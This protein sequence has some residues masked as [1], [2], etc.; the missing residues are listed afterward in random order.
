[1]AL[2]CSAGRSPIWCQPSPRGGRS[3]KRAG[4]RL[5][6]GERI[7]ELIDKPVAELID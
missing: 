5:I 4:Q 1:M 7:A 3:D 2:A 6:G